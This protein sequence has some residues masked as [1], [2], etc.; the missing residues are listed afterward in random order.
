MKKLLMRN[1]A[2]S[3][4]D[5]SRL[6]AVAQLLGI[7]CVGSPDSGLWIRGPHMKEAHVVDYWRG[8]ARLLA[9]ICELTLYWIPFS[10]SESCATTL[11]S[12]SDQRLARIA[13]LYHRRRETQ[14]VMVA[15][16]RAVDSED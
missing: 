3:D 9:E 4:T 6:R 15:E 13:E 14:N 5:C 12:H 10:M 11:L 1:V 8:H 7:S 16:C 2:L